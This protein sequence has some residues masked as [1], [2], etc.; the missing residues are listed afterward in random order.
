VGKQIVEKYESYEDVIIFPYLHSGRLKKIQK[1]TKDYFCKPGV[2]GQGTVHRH[3]R[4]ALYIT[5]TKC[6]GKF[7]NPAYIT[8]SKTMHPSG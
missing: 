2:A 6:L 3:Q 1:E 8:Q 5:R 7:I 4:G